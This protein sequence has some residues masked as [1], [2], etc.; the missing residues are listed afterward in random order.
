MSDILVPAGSIVGTEVDWSRDISQDMQ[1]ER[2]KTESKVG[3]LVPKLDV[4]GL[5][6]EHQIER[7][8]LKNRAQSERQE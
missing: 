3:N 5:V 4:L 6:V 7:H 2:C 8:H 1:D